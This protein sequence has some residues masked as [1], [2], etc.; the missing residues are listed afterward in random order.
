MAI[1]LEFDKKIGNKGMNVPLKL[2]Q[3]SS[4]LLNALDNAGVP[5][6][7]LKNLKSLAA[8]KTYNKK[9]PGSKND[10]KQTG[11]NYISADVAKKR[12]QRWPKNKVLA[13]AQGGKEALDFYTKVVQ[14]AGRQ[15]EVSPVEPPKPTI[16]KASKPEIPKA[17]E[18]PMPN[19]KIKL[20]ASVAPRKVMKESEDDW[21]PYYDAIPTTYEILVDFLTSN[22]PKQHW[23]LIE[24]KPYQKALQEF[25]QYGQFVRFP[26]DYIYDWMSIIMTNTGQLRT[27][28]EWLGKEMYFPTDDLIEAAEKY[29][30]K[31]KDAIAKYGK[32]NDDNGYDIL[33]YIGFYDWMELPDGS[34]GGSDYGTPKLEKVISEYREGMPPEKVIVIINKALD[35]VHCQGDLSSAFIKG[36][37]ITLSRISRGLQIEEGKKNKK[38]YITEEQVLKIKDYGKKSN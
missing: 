38:I 12:K 28:G 8:T 30:D 31:F 24:P 10:K 27:N 23:D 14:M 6:Q 36:G 34:I 33:D 11:T 20:A 22:E 21:H 32:I 37:R 15:Q 25:M 4:T 19:G 9:K 2:Q 35:I 5:K 1:I 16:Q 18:I 3:D 7:N 26:T 17:K 29:P 13:A